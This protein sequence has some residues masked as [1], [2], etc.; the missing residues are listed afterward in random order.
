MTRFLRS[1]GA[2]VL[3]ALAVSAHAQSISPSFGA[4][5]PSFPVVTASL[6]VTGSM[7]EEDAGTT[8][9]AVW[10][11]VALVDFLPDLTSVCHVAPP[12]RAAGC[13]GAGVYVLWPA[14]D[15]TRDIL[16]T[17]LAHEL[18][19]VALWIG[20]EAEA[21]NCAARVITE[22]QQSSR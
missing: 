8:F 5:P 19:H 13:I 17:A 1:T 7:L 2:A 6:G 12:Y 22:Y 9:H 3:A 20:T 21:E 14:P 15:G 4:I 10:N 16:H 11:G 18:C